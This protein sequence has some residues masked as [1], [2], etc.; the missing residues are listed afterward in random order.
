[1]SSNLNTNDLVAEI[2][3]TTGVDADPQVVALL[4][5]MAEFFFNNFD[6]YAGI[7]GGDGSLEDTP[8]MT[9]SVFATEF[10]KY[11]PE[12]VRIATGKS[13]NKKN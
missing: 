6:C 8:A 7:D 5:K 10:P 11:L 3:K 9:F 12:I 1:M 4:E 13:G 2:K